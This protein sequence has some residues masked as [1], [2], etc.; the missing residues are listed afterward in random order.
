MNGVAE[1]IENGGDVEVDVVVM[2]PDVGHWQSDVFGESSRAIYADALG[3]STLLPA[4]G[5]AVTAASTDDVPFAADDFTGMKIVDVGTDGD[6]FANEFMTDDQGHGDGALG[7]FVPVMNVQVGAADASAENADENIVNADFGFGDVFD[8]EAGFGFAF[9]ESFHFF[10]YGGG[11]GG[12]QRSGLRL[13]A[14]GFAPV[15]NPD[16]FERIPKIPK[17]YIPSI[18]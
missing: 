11:R 6:Y 10:Q 17:P 7:P 3:V 18:H 4:A 5:H 2:L 1:G 8:P 14:I 12:W 13:L 16:N 9:D 15:E